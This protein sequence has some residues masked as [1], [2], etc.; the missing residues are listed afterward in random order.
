MARRIVR[1]H[2][3]EGLPKGA[4][5]ISR[6]KWVKDGDLLKRKRERSVIQV[7]ERIRA[8]KKYYV[9]DKRTGRI[10]FV[11]IAHRDGREYIRTEPDDDK[12]DN[13]LALKMF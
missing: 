4:H 2:I 10:A 11:T 1:I 13:L 7:I 6:V 3:D 5:H 9:K 12:L 8:G